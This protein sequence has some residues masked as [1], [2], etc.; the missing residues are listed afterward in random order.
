MVRFTMQ[1]WR[2]SF[3]EALMLVGAA[4]DVRI[5]RLVNPLRTVRVCLPKI[6]VEGW[7]NAQ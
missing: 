6:A 3:E 1:D 2:L 5:S 7:R 4:G